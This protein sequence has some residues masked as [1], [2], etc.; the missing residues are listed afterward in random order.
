MKSRNL[1]RVMSEGMTGGVASPP[2]V[3]PPLSLR[4]RAPFVARKGRYS[5]NPA[6]TSTIASSTASQSS[7]ISPAVIDS[8]GDNGRM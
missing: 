6:E 1:E 5:A 8:G 7:S 2:P 4:S 3:H